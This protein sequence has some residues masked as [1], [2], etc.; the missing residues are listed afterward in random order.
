MAK[1]QEYF[2]LK[3]TAF[4]DIVLYSLIEVHLC[5]KGAYC[6]CHQGNEGSAM[7]MEAIHTSETS[8]TQK[9]VIIVFITMRT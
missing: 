3:M 4:W 9:A 7:M 8:V 2:V 1:L 5:F 6:L